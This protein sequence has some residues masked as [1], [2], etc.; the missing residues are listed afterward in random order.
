MLRQIESGLQNG[1]ITKNEDLLGTNLFFR[2]VY[3]TLKTLY[4]ELI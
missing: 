3:F 4:K 2:K 1:S